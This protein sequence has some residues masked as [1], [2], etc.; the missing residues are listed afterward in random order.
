MKNAQKITVRE[1]YQY[2][3]SYKEVRTT[4]N[5]V[6]KKNTLKIKY[7]NISSDMSENLTKISI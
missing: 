4:I 5:D 7:P 3:K 6:N 1:I 2:I